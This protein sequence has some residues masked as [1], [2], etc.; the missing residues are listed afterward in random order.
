MK[1]RSPQVAAA[2]PQSDFDLS[3]MHRYKI[4]KRTLAQW[5]VHRS[6]TTQNWIA[7][8]SRP[9]QQ[10][11]EKI[12]HIQFPFATEKEARTFCKSYAP[13]KMSSSTVCEICATH[14][15][16]TVRHCR[17]CGASVCD[18][19]SVRW[20][21]RMVPKT[22]SSS[23]ALTQRV[24]KS[25]DWLSNAF[26]MSLLKG[27]FAEAQTL[28]QTG[29]V[30]L[31][32][33]F[34]D[35]REEAM[36]PIHTAVMGGS[37]ELVRWLVDVQL[38][39]ISVRTDPKTGSMLSV[40]TSAGRTLLDLAMTGLRPKL[41][42]LVFL[43]RKGL[44][45]TDVKNPALVPKTLEAILKAGYPLDSALPTKAVD[46]PV[47]GS[48]EETSTCIEDLCCLC[49]EQSMDCVLTPCGHQMCCITCGQ[50]L[51]QCPLC[52]TDCSALKVFRQ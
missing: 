15:N 16:P 25:C 39:P 50:Q 6:L 12:R 43:I 44:T 2:E 1:V 45:L 38:C 23:A 42:I 46:I 48:V 4:I 31:R 52:K 9:D 49:C 33:S 37:F 40:Q 41:D 8:I 10:N 32:T 47:D 11:P 22:Y 29:N 27:R 36:F 18:K 5:S 13:P 24:C 30:N 35:I 7:T 51:K 20:G 28:F 17:N 3:L 19:C 14:P 21:A 26:C 34:A